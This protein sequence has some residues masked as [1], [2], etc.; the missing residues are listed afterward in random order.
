MVRLA[1]VQDIHQVRDLWNYCF[2]DTPE[3]V[4]FYFQTCYQS[5]NTLVAED[6]G[7]I[8]SSLQLLP[9]R[10]FLRE[11]EIPVSYI[12]GVATWPE[13]RGRGLVRELLEFADTILH[14]RGIFQS[15]LLP[16]QYEFY[17]KYGWEVCYDFLTYKS[18]ESLS[19]HYL[20][21]SKDNKS[22]H[23]K[24][25][26]VD[27]DDDI[28]KITECYNQYMERFH[29]YIIRGKTEWSK[30][31]HDVTLDG[32]A[33]YL[34]EEN[35]KVLGYIMYTIQDKKLN[36]RE[37]IYISHD[38]KS[39]LVNLAF[40]HIGQV[41]QICR[42]AHAWDMDYLY[43]KDSR[44]RLEKE[45]FVMGRIHNV[46]D[47]LSDLPYSGNKFVMKIN[48]DFC[49][50]NNGNFLIKRK[51]WTSYVKETN[52]EPDIILDIRTLNQLLWGYM[53]PEIAVADG[54]VD[55]NNKAQLSNLEL[56]FSMKYNYMTEDY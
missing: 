20:K 14:E 32:G 30:L 38:A 23:V 29:G 50:R 52:Q 2:D 19:Y 28:V 7:K 53:S 34:Y 8:M 4:D 11:R 33:C 15:I 5:E 44:G 13:Y 6:E 51:H 41:E 36:I 27:L 43:M 49:H 10:M 55:L 35:E 45:T 24:F 56:L 46:I 31:I 12:V 22:A 1:N 26:K 18:L 25:K 3:F 54:R 37:L 9:Y 40:S 48:D 21:E 47:A 42:K 39:A 16:F 17:R